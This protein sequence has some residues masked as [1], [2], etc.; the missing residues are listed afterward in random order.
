MVDEK[1]EQLSEMVQSFCDEYLNDEYKHE[2]QKIIEK[3]ANRKSVLFKRGRL[4]VWA[5][6]VIYAVCQIN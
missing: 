5:S 4:E 6:A 3:M 1:Q 2:S